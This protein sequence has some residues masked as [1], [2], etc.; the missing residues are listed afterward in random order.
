MN[1]DNSAGT[2]DLLASNRT[3]LAWIRTSVAFAGLGF[4]AAAR[5]PGGIPMACGHS[6]R[7]LR[8]SMRP[9]PRLP[10]CHREVAALPSRSNHAAHFAEDP[11]D[12]NW[13][14]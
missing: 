2:L 7:Y 11:N 6:R 10:G 1:G 14:S 3:L 8:R 4:V 5:R 13:L 9:A 12:A